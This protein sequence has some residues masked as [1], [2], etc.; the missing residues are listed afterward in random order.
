MFGGLRLVPL[1][2]AAHKYFFAIRGLCW[3]KA[4]QEQKRACL[5]SSGAP[6][7]L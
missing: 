1:Q 3:C 4:T 6:W 2:G 7:A 5:T